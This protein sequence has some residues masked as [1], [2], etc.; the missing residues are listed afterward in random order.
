[1]A[2]RYNAPK[3]VVGRQITTKSAFG[4]H[5][6]MIVQLEDV[7]IETLKMILDTTLPKKIA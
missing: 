1:M 7:N 2:K 4:S 6:D 5:S 3:H